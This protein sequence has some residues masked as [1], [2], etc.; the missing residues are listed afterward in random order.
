M[1]ISLVENADL[2]YPIYATVLFVVR[3][4]FVDLKADNRKTVV[5]FI[6]KLVRSHSYIMQVPLNLAYAVRL[7]S[8]ERSA[9]NEELLHGIYS[10][11]RTSRFGGI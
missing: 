1:V 2:L 6:R 9:E 11:Q 7:L 8:S 5:E 4:V 3:H 10:Q